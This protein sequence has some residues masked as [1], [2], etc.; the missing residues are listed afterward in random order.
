MPTKQISAEHA[1]ERFK[2][3]IKLNVVFFEAATLS[4]MLAG[5]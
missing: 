2:F 1:E 5:F 3:G 4:A